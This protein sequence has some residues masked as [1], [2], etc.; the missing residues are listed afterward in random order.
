MVCD[1]GIKKPFPT[2][3]FHLIFIVGV[4]RG[5]PHFSSR[6]FAPPRLAKRAERPATA[7]GRRTANS[8]NRP[9]EDTPMPAAAFTGAAFPVRGLVPP[10]DGA[11][12]VELELSEEEDEDEDEDAE[13]EEPDAEDELGEELDEEL[14]EDDEPDDEEE[15]DEEEA[16]EE[17]DEDE[18]DDELAMMPT[19]IV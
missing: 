4:P 19:G 14:L 3:F 12:P 13:E 17:L 1:S 8:A 9:M 16:E 5:Y 11:A 18:L 7:D 15:P 6:G 10:V 2:A